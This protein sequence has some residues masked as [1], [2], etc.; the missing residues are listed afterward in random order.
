[1]YK[2]TCKINTGELVRQAE[3]KVRPSTHEPDLD[4]ANVGKVMQTLSENPNQDSSI[5]Y[6]YKQI[7]EVCATLR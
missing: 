2:Y 6:F 3:R 7:V 4:N 1:M 5:F